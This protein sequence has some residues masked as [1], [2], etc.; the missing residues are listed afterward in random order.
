MNATVC[1]ASMVLLVTIMFNIIP[2]TVL[3]V[4][5]ELDAINMSIGVRTIL[6]KMEL[7]VSRRRTSINV[8]VLLVGPVKSATSKWFLVKMRL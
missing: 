4:I 3:T 6:A 8:I 7:L 2:V 1:P 5:L